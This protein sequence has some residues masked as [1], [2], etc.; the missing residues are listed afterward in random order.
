MRKYNYRRPVVW[1]NGMRWKQPTVFGGVLKSGIV[2][3][4]WAEV[5]GLISPS[6]RHMGGRLAS[7]LPLLMCVALIVPAAMKTR[8]LQ[9]LHVWVRWRYRAI[10]A[11]GK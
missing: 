4:E 9:R 11:A 5:P 6:A 1:W 8:A 3:T 10:T 2:N 7:V